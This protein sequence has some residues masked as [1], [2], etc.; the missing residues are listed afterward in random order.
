MAQLNLVDET[1]KALPAGPAPALNLVDASGKALAGSTPDVS[2]KLDYGNGNSETSDWLGSAVT[3]GKHFLSAAN[4]VPVDLLKS[5][6]ERG[7][8]ETAKSIL[9]AQG[10]QFDKAKDAFNKGDYMNAGRYTLGWLLP[11]IGPAANDAGD[12][13]GRGE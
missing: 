6:Y 2:V 1:G 3:F 13:L 10:A 9:G 4:P 5:I 7:N 11:L 12:K 8:I